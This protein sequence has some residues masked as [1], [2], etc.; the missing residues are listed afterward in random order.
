MYVCIYIYIYLAPEPEA[1]ITSTPKPFR[2]ISSSPDVPV[3]PI[4]EISDSSAVPVLDI[5]ADVHP[6]P[7]TPPLAPPSETDTG[8]GST[9]E[10][11]APDSPYPETIGS[12]ETE[13]QI[14]NVS[15]NIHI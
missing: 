7:E 5:H 10:S 15:L 8:F 1:K 14:I 6:T 11:S 9:I 2:E 13:E 4:P 3:S 12:V